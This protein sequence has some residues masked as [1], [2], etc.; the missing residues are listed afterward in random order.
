MSMECAIC[1]KKPMYGQ[2]IRH[3]HSGAWSRRAPRT[4]RRFMPNLQMVHAMVN[5]KR[6]KLRV[7]TKCIKKPG[8]LK[9]A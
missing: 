3:V 7:C 1:G 6:T 5:G 8:L 9:I 2:N 4:K